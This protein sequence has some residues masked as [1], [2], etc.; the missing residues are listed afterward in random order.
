MRTYYELNTVILNNLVKFLLL[1]FLKCITKIKLV[2]KTTLKQFSRSN[3][4]KK[5]K[6]LSFLTL[7]IKFLM[8]Y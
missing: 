4:L 6:F 5:K 3:K 2:I 1:R 8:I 7:K